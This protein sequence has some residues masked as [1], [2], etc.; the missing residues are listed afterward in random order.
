MIK[1]LNQWTATHIRDFNP[2]TNVY[3]MV[4]SLL[5]FSLFS[6]LLFN[7][8]TV[9]FRPSSGNPGWLKPDTLSL[10]SFVPETAFSLN[11]IRLICLLLLVV[12]MSGWRPRVTAFFHVY[13]AYSIN[14]AA[15]VIDGG[16]QVNLVIS[17]LLLPLAISAT[18]KSDLST[19]NC[20][21]SLCIH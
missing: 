21:C 14:A 15:T 8:A 20:L 9:L 17:V 16:E 12:V 18:N 2:W 7:D 10:F 6:T 13:V 4:R 19:N 11:I 3:G 5:A 1:Q